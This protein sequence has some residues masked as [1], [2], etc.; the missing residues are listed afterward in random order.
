MRRQGATIALPPVIQLG[1]II[2]TEMEM[3]AASFPL[4]Q[5][6]SRAAGVKSAAVSVAVTQHGAA[7]TGGGDV[8]AA[9]HQCLCL[10]IQIPVAFPCSQSRG[11]EL[12]L[13]TDFNHVEPMFNP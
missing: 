5:E 2:T 10:H 12:C 6:E 4:R 1:I 11:R 8:S 3:K 7:I 9:H 13:H